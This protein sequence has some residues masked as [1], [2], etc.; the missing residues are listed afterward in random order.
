[1]RLIHTADWHLGNNIHDVD[2]RGEQKAFLDWLARQIEEQEADTLV[3]AGDIF[4]VKRPKTEA[5]ELYFDFLSK[6][7]DS[8]CKNVVIIGGNHDSGKFLE[9]TKSIMKK[10]NIFVVGTASEKSAAD[11]VFALK[12]EDGED[13]A[14][15]AAV[16]YMQE[17]ELKE[18]YGEDFEDG[19]FSDLAYQSVF[20]ACLAYAET[21]QAGR[22]LPVVAISHLYAAGLEGRYEGMEAE[23]STDD[24]VK[25]LDVVGKLGKIHADV[26]PAGFDYVG[27]G[28][29]HYTTKVGGEN[30]IRYSGSPFVM[31]FD[32]A[33]IPHYVLRVDMGKAGEAVKVRKI[34][35]PQT[36]EFRR[37]EGNKEEILEQL[38]GIIQQREEAAAAKEATPAYLELQYQVDEG[39]ELA[40]AI[41]QMAL[42]PGVSIVSWKPVKKSAGC[43]EMFAEGYDVRSMASISLEDI[44]RHLVLTKKPLS[45]EEREGKTEDEILASE[46]ALVEK[47]LPYFQ[48]ALNAV[49][50]NDCEN[51]KA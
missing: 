25:V 34:T 46:N 27:L 47:Y 5:E 40:D 41:D 33:A 4:D 7:D 17:Y 35:V 14:I 21:L 10:F 37:L 50:V 16:P 43:S 22:S 49:E 45:P 15:I 38:R 8:S 36:L 12:D 31:G 51:T 1:M 30:R 13:Y 29:I 9:A 19:R 48:E 23:V 44:V 39:R 6:I 24:G 11:M 28:H 26:F 32:D 18:Y 2:R 3:V 20:E 42:P